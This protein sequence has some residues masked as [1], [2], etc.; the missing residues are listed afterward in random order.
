LVWLG[1]GFSIH[2][3][4]VLLINLTRSAWKLLKSLPFVGILHKNSLF[5]QAIGTV[6][7]GL[8]LYNWITWVFSTD[9]GIGVTSDGAFSLLSLFLIPVGIFIFIRL[10][11]DFLGGLKNELQI[12]INKIQL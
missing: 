11:I 2:I 10:L 9:H 12:Q 7:V 5:V 3:F 6:G 4:I 8:V 1:Y